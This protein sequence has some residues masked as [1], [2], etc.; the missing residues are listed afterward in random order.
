[1]EIIACEMGKYLDV[2][3]P[4]TYPAKVFDAER[5]L[6]YGALIE[7]FY[8]A[9][10]VEYQDGER[11][12]VQEIPD[13]DCKAGEQHN[14]DTILHL[15]IFKSAF[16]DALKYWA[17]VLMF[18]S[19]IGNTDRHQMNWGVIR[20]ISEQ[21][22]CNRQLLTFIG[23]TIALSPAFDNGSSMDYQIQEDKFSNKLN[24]LQG[25]LEKGEH[26][27]AFDLPSVGKKCNFFTFMSK[28]TYTFDIAKHECICMV[29][30]FEKHSNQIE[31]FIREISLLD[32]CGEYNFTPARAEFVITCMHKRVELLKEAI[33]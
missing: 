11:F 18:D 22:D 19:I 28:F 25:Y 17:K 2:P 21:Y 32:S 15:P 3:V 16:D 13:F 12:M 26:H 31:S 5:Q 24:V 1:M 33:S 14:L 9:G 7:W 23:D 8:Q 6:K 20:N 27:M 10:E 4:P 29:Q 30:S